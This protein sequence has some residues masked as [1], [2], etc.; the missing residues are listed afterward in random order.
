MSKHATALAMVATSRRSAR[1][2]SWW[3][4]WSLFVGGAPAVGAIGG[5]DDSAE[6][7]ELA[8]VDQ[9]LPGPGRRGTPRPAR[10]RS[11]RPADGAR[12]V[13]QKVKQA[14]EAQADDRV[15]APQPGRRD[16][17]PGRLVQRAGRLPHPAGRQQ[18]GLG[19][20]SLTRMGWAHSLI[21]NA[22]VS[23]VGFQ[24]FE[25]PQYYR[26]LALTGQRWE[27]F[28]GPDA[29]PRLD[30]QLARVGH[31]G[32]GAG[33]GAGRRD[34]LLR[35]ADHPPAGRAAQEHRVRARGVVLQHPQPGRRPR[36]RRPG[37]RAP[38]IA[39]PDQPRQ[40]AEQGRHPG[41]ASPAT[42]TT[43]PRRSAR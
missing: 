1:S 6:G 35:R 31:Q 29:R 27:V 9:P 23:V 24:E 41:G 43:A 17:V 8:G 36:Q 33:R 12:P 37:Y 5:D 7:T 14:Q 3:R 11:E 22:D 39:H 18:E 21:R 25:H 38:A 34:P 15:A 4:S 20:R 42:S 19:R 26:F 13:V 28:P 30:P 10:P 40:R 2:S 16:H 32:L